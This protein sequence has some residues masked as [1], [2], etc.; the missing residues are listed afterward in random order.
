MSCSHFYI[1]SLSHQKGRFSRFIQR[2]FFLSYCRF[3][4]TFLQV[5]E[6]LVYCGLTFRL[7]CLRLFRLEFKIAS[8]TNLFVS[9]NDCESREIFTFT[10]KF[11]EGSASVSIATSSN[12]CFHHFPAVFLLRWRKPFFKK[13]KLH[14][15]LIFFVLL[16]FSQLMA[17]VGNSAARAKYEQKVPAFYY[18]P[19][20]TDCK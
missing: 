14:L 4:V 6:C 8:P 17:A 12:V 11:S 10:T 5:W 18:R 9:H 7:T 1:S 19:T 2:W 13:K 15:S 3:T 20:H 16:C